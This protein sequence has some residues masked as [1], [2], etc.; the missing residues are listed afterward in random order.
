MSTE[1]LASTNWLPE[2]AAE[3]PESIAQGWKTRLLTTS[4]GNAA[5]CLEN[6]LVAL[7]YAPEWRDVVHFNES[8]L[9]VI[10]KSEPPWD[11]RTLPFI[12]RDDDDVRAAAW[13]QRQGIM[14]GQEICGQAIQTIARESAFHPIKDYLESL[15]WDG[16]GRIDD[17]LTLYLGVDPKDYVRAVGAKWL[18]GA[19][20]RVYRP[21]CKNDTCPIFEGPQGS[22][23]SMML[24]T[25]ASDDFFTDDMAELGSK[26]S[27]L[28]TRGVWVIELAE[29]DAMGKSESSRIKAFMSRQV[30]RIRLPYGRRVIEVPRECVFAGT[31]NHDAYLKDETGGR[32]FWPIRCGT[33]KIDDLRRDRNQLW[34]EA[35]D[36]FNAGEHWWLDSPKLTAAA[37][38]EQ[39]DRY[40]ADPWQPLIEKWIDGREHVTV[41]QVLT[42]C[43]EKPARDWT[44]SDKNRIARSLKALHWE[45]YQKR[46]ENG[47]REWRYRKSPPSPPRG[48]KR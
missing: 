26:D 35:R 2:Q 7:T 20:A 12:W 21:G 37:A 41:E 27:V 4:R 6:A 28:Q 47:G 11:S 18:I 5:A 23:K 25:L 34:A 14:V 32:R 40:D 46:I 38:D 15:A 44:Q 3:A 13:M 36:R 16:I 48:A 33:I 19:V 31:V 39:Q 8:S 45:R 29:L 42:N 22:L 9:Q 17:W 24:R 43:L 10:A 30:D 1:P